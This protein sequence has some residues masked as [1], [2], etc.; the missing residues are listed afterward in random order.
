MT[1][2]KIPRKLVSRWRRNKN[3]PFCRAIP[4]H[5]VGVEEHREQRT[6]TT[7][8]PSQGKEIK[9]TRSQRLTAP[10]FTLRPARRN[11]MKKLLGF[12]RLT[13]YT[14]FILSVWLTPT[15]VLS[16]VLAEPVRPE[17]E[18]GERERHCNIR[19]HPVE[20]PG[21][22]SKLSDFECFDNFSEAVYA[23]TNGL[24]TLPA[25]IQPVEFSE[26]MLDIEALKIRGSDVPI[27]T[28]YDWRNFR[29]STLT[30]WA[31]GTCGWF[32]ASKMP[33]GWND[34]VSSTKSY[35]YCSVNILYK[36][37]LYGGSAYWCWNPWGTK[38]EC[39]DLGS[40]NNEASSREWF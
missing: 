28:D 5:Q 19:I 24:V 35:S 22:V 9:M 13:V 8:R 10:G 18:P 39:G 37:T 33:S 26:E 12:F 25:D 3:C 4:R 27:S 23:G 17:R 20:A 14:T 36:H 31:S 32:L 34:D 11:T 40:M 16:Q 15:V 6:L 1:S 29:G 7:R 30:W 2:L 21:E 38:A